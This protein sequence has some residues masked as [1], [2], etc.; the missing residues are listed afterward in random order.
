MS[1]EQPPS[2]DDYIDGAAAL[3]PPLDYPESATHNEEDMGEEG[4]LEEEEEEEDETGTIA[5]NPRIAISQLYK[6]S[7]GAGIYSRAYYDVAKAL[8]LATLLST[9]WKYLDGDEVDNLLGRFEEELDSTECSE[10]TSRLLHDNLYVLRAHERADL[11]LG[12]VDRDTSDGEISKGLV[13]KV[14][15]EVT[16]FFLSGRVFCNSRPAEVLDDVHYVLELR[17]PFHQK[18]EIAS[19]ATIVWPHEGFKVEGEDGLNRFITEHRQALR[20]YEL[21]KPPKVTTTTALPGFSEHFPKFIGADEAKALLNTPHRQVAPD[22]D[23]IED[24]KANMPMW[25]EC[26]FTALASF[27]DDADDFQ[28]KQWDEFMADMKNGKFTLEQ[29][30]AVSWLVLQEAI[31][32]YED[33]CILIGKDDW[34]SKYHKDQDRMCSERLEDI[35]EV[36]AHK[37]IAVEIFNH[38]HLLRLVAAPRE[39]LRA[40][41]ANA[42]S[43]EIRKAKDQERREN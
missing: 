25:H 29:L 10:D 37:R 28:K 36:L 34:C 5:T 12:D 30:D 19:M 23:D 3:L 26:I 20:L 11:G 18:M 16:K 4:E 7:Q 43:N 17:I 33:G 15:E 2:T 27:P 35:I 21:Q 31:R 14:T 39:S 8:S 42:K 6:Q 9:Y 40:K 1:F 13:R 38:G 24:V 22:V 41:T 32:L